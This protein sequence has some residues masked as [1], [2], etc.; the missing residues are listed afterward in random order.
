LAGNPGSVAGNWKRTTH[1]LQ[2]LQAEVT[3]EGEA[4]AKDCQIK[5]RRIH[6]HRRR[7]EQ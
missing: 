2:R 6:L 4:H 3:R 7:D 5:G 1:D